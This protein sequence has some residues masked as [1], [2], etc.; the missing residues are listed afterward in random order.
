METVSYF[1]KYKFYVPEWEKH[2]FVG[3]LLQ[4]KNENEVLPTASHAWQRT[5]LFKAKKN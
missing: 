1:L 5:L 3:I 4:F 2:R